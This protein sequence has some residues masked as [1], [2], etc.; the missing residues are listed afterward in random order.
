MKITGR[1][2]RA[3]RGGDRASKLEEQHIQPLRTYPGLEVSTTTVSQTLDKQL[4]T[5]KC[6]GRDTDVP[7]VRNKS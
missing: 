6:L 5:L 3:R 7:V 2:D 4:I 1:R